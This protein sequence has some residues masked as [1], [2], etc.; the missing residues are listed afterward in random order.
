MTTKKATLKEQ[1]DT[2]VYER[3]R[4]LAKNKSFQ[5]QISRLRD[6]IDGLAAERDHLQQVVN[7]LKINLSKLYLMSKALTLAYD[8]NGRAAQS[9]DWAAD[10]IKV[11]R[12][13]A[14]KQQNEE[15][16][17]TAQSVPSVQG[18]AATETVSERSA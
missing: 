7:Q 6:A 10:S 14:E 3:D 12:G 9:L 5:Q 1:I 16:Q 8:A 11:N 17:G 18:V 4:E 13:S 15:T 2:L